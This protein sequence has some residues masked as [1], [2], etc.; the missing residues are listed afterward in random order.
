MKSPH[1]PRPRLA[2]CNA[3]C[4]HSAWRVRLDLVG[5]CG[6]VAEA[7]ELEAS[8]WGSKGK[9][10]IPGKAVSVMPAMRSPGWRALTEGE[11]EHPQDLWG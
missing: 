1:A 5:P 11:A 10:I 6:R 2:W 7:N 4:R 8:A 9:T 3:R